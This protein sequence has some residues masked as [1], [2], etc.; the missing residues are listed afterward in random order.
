MH[1]VDYATL[2]TVFALYTRDNVLDNVQLHAAYIISE[3]AAQ[4]LPLALGE[5]TKAPV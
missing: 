5:R 2:L 1:W 4:T 3:K